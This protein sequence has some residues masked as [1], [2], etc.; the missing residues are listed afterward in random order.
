MDIGI[1]KETYVGETRA[2]LIPF[3]VG[4]L[5]RQGNR[6]VIQSEAGAASGFDDQSYRDMGATIA[7]SAEEAFSRSEIVL[8]SYDKAYEQGFEDMPRRVPDTTKI[9]NFIGKM[10]STYSLWNVKEWK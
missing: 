9:K 1:V 8:V 5:I 2:P 10:D 6:V 7:Y 3:A 4:E